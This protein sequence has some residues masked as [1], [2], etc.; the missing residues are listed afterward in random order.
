M[1]VFFPVDLLLAN[2]SLCTVSPNYSQSI[3][4]NIGP[5]DSGTIVPSTHHPTVLYWRLLDF[6]SITPHQ[7]MKKPRVK[8][9]G[10]GWLNNSLNKELVFLKKRLNQINRLNFDSFPPPKKFPKVLYPELNFFDVFLIMSFMINHTVL[11][12]PHR[13]FT[14]LNPKTISPF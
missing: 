1:P 5:F 12:I 9:G 4:K 3:K 14:R 10:T 8:K 2:L 7:A 11:G 13:N 6:W